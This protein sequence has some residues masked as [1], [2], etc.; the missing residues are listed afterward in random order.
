MIEGKAGRILSFCRL[1]CKYCYFIYVLHYNTLSHICNTGVLL[2]ITEKFSIMCGISG[3]PM[4]VRPQC[5]GSQADTR[6]GITGRSIGPLTYVDHLPEKALIYHI[7]KT[8]RDY[9]ILQVFSNIA[10]FILC[11]HTTLCLTY[12]IRTFCQIPREN[13]QSR[14]EFRVPCRAPV[15]VSFRIELHSRIGSFR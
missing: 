4:D 1:F 5:T 8:C 7:R 13:F 10:I 12:V 3:V 6:P 11:C 15:R 14:A 2:G 9:N